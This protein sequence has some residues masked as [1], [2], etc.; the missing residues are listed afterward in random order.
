MRRKERKRLCWKAE[1]SS[2]RHWC[3]LQGAKPG[4]G[5][6]PQ[7]LLPCHQTTKLALSPLLP[8]SISFI[9]DSRER[10]KGALSSSHIL[11]GAT[12]RLSTLLCKHDQG[13]SPELSS[14]ALSGRQLSAITTGL[15]KKDALRGKIHCS[16]SLQQLRSW[17][18]SPY[19]QLKSSHSL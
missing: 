4:R 15:S 11:R 2:V 8:Q 1:P 7:R 6:K 13:K 3:G 19:S 9:C 10:R 18:S 5:L 12:K 17:C 14:T 16:I